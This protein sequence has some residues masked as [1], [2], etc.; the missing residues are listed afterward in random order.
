MPW[1]EYVELHLLQALEMRSTTGRQP[2]P[3]ELA[4]RVA[5][6]YDWIDGRFVEAPFEYVP[7]GAA[8]GMS[9]TAADMTR[10][11]RMHLGKG[12]FA[13]AR[14]LRDHSARTMREPAYGSTPGI[15]SILHGFLERSRTGTFIYG[16]A[17]G[18]LRFFSEL[19]LI[20]RDDI[21]VFVATNTRQGDRVVAAVLDGFLDRYFAHVEWDAEQP[22]REIPNPQALAGEWA[23]YRHPLTTPDKLLRLLQPVFVSPVSATEIRIDGLGEA[24]GYWRLTES[25]LFWNPE[26]RRR[27]W[28]ELASNPPQLHLDS[29]VEAYYKLE[30]VHALRLQAPLLLLSLPILLWALV[31]WPVR[32]WRGEILEGRLLHLRLAGWALAIAATLV[33]AL[34]AIQGEELLL[35]VTRQLQALLWVSWTVPLATACYGVTVARHLREAATRRAG[36]W[37]TWLLWYWSLYGPYGFK[38]LAPRDW[39]LFFTYGW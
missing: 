1:Y 22:P 11:A 24:P 2:H 12:E 9:A 3:A 17:G 23:Y 33:M 25:G 34:L 4:Q 10:F 35:G 8:G 31:V 6:G 28:F 36:G 21:S 18:T 15:D 39:G 19:A 38:L 13:G 26:T 29:M 5:R 7:L 32:F 30:G 37:F 20:P 27:I 14:I 16:H